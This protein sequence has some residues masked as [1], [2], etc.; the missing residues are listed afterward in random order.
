MIRSK[1]SSSSSKFTSTS[2]SSSASGD[3]HSAN[4]HNSY[5]KILPLSEAYTFMNGLHHTTL[6]E[7]MSKCA[8][9]GKNFALKEE[10][11]VIDA[12]GV[13]VLTA[14]S[15]HEYWVKGTEYMDSQFTIDDNGQ[16]VMGDL[17]QLTLIANYTIESL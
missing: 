6:V 2:S 1:F 9:I 14:Y 7:D 12:S 17:S 13:K 4:Y 15:E 8:Q 3:T 11:N 16:K 5:V 10:F